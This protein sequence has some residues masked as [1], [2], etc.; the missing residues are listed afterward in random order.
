MDKRVEDFLGY[1]TTEK[2]ASEHTTKNYAIDLREFM[3]FLG[4][5]SLQELTYLDIRSFLAFLKARIQKEFHCPQARVPP[6]FF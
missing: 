6:F 3:K 1:L 4:E 2:G 5:K